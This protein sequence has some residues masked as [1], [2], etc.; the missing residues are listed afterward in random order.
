VSSRR[1]H[2]LVFSC[3]QEVKDEVTLC[4]DCKQFFLLPLISHQVV[5]FTFER[6]K[7]SILNSKLWA[8]RRTDD[9]EDFF[10]EDFETRREKS[11]S[12][13]VWFLVLLIV[14]L[15]YYTVTFTKRN[16]FINGGK[17][18]SIFLRHLSS[19]PA[20]RHPLLPSSILTHLISQ[21][22]DW[23][24]ERRVS[25]EVSSSHYVIFLSLDV[26]R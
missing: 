22:K 20:C 14:F 17:L 11:Q 23:R 4:Y 18:S 21:R 26:S 12:H 25:R 8:R 5:F 2:E 19:L 13:R 3:H 6:G 15:S 24:E 10:R 9:R 16:V 1:I 7:S